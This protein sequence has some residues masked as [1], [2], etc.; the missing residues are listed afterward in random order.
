[1]KQAQDCENMTDIR[2]SIDNIDEQIVRLIAS[3]AGYVTAAACF[4]KDETAVRDT[5]RVERVITSKRE[6]AVQQGVSPDMIEEIYRVM[7]DHF[8]NDEMQEWKAG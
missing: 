6:L 4:K 8:I 2:E 1:M 3:R 5:S 7:I